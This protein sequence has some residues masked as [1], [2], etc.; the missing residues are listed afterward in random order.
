MFGVPGL[1]R[2]RVSVSVTFMFLQRHLASIYDTIKSR[3]AFFKRDNGINK[4]IMH[5][6]FQD[7]LDLCLHFAI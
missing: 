1:V 2:F 5:Y 3:I 7:F 6:C 4:G